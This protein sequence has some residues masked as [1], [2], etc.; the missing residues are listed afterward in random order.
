[1]L[2]LNCTHKECSSWQSLQVAVASREFNTCIIFTFVKD[3]AG[4]PGK[5]EFSRI[6][7]R[8]ASCFRIV[9]AFHG[10]NVLEAKA[11]MVF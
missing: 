6:P 4:F 8:K 10:T 9:S 7:S 5:N 11:A 2:G 1:M 3:A